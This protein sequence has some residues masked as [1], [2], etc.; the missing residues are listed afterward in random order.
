MRPPFNP[1]CER[2]RTLKGCSSK[3]KG[4]VEN[5]MG[6]NKQMFAKTRTFAVLPSNQ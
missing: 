4:S 1:L 6:K 3:L 2:F 5:A